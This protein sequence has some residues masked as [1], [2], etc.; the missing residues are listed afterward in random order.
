V[1]IRLGCALT[2]EIGYKNAIF[3]SPSI[4]HRKHVLLGFSSKVP[5]RLPYK[6]LGELCGTSLQLDFCKAVPSLTPS[7]MA[8]R[9][10][11]EGTPPA[12][13]T[14]RRAVPKVQL[15]REHFAHSPSEYLHAEAWRPWEISVALLV[16]RIREQG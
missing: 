13:P 10:K 6:L 9:S 12:P 16:R 15:R 14:S 4:L 5:S 7:F 2:L 8:W 11:I 1:C 3:S